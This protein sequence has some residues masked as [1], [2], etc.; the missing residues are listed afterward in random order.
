MGASDIKQ[1]F[2]YGDAQ[3]HLSALIVTDISVTELQMRIDEINA[4][5]PDYARIKDFKIVPAFTPQNGTL[6]PN[7]RLRREKILTL[8]HKEKSNELLQSTC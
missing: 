6:T 4:K 3:P 8:Y 7:G 1:A 5:L 2:V